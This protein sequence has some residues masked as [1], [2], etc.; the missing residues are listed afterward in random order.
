MEEV[1]KTTTDN[2]I[3]IDNSLAYLYIVFV[4]LFC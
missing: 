2:N 3:V 4:L 1:G